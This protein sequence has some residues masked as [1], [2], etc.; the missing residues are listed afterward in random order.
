M[1]KGVFYPKV[2]VLAGEVPWEYCLLVF[3]SAC[4]GLR[5]GNS[6]SV[7]TAYF[8]LTYVILGKGGLFVAPLLEDCLT[9]P[10]WALLPELEQV[11]LNYSLSIAVWVTARHWHFPCIFEIRSVEK[12][13][14]H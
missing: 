9:G 6:R 13:Y 11:L 7:L 14:Y 1:L 12:N 5:T 4:G 8:L 3:F 2:A 10:Y